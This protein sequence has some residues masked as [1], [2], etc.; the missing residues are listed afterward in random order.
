[1]QEFRIG[2]VGAGTI[3]TNH[4]NALNEIEG[5]RLVAVAEPREEAGRKLAGGNNAQWYSSLE[6]LL[7]QSDVDVVVLGTPS[8]LHADQ[9]VQAA[10][11]GKHVIT[12]KPMSI[13]LE[14]ADR[15]IEAARASGVT[16]SCIFQNRFNRD[17]L[18]LK[19]G[20]EAGLFGQPLIGN[21]FV[22][23][24]R[25]Q[26]YYDAAGG[27]RG[28]Y[29]MDGGGALMNQSIHTVDL[30][31]WVMGPV[32]SLCGYAETLA[33]NIEGEDTAS[34]TL[35]FQSGALGSIQG[36]TSAHKGRPVRV[37]IIGTEGAATL[38]GSKIT[39]WQ[40]SRE[41][42]V[43]TEEDIR[44]TREPTDGESFARSHITQMRLIF[45]ALREGRTPPIP[46]EEARK[47]LELVLG[48]YQS[49]R[50]GERVTFPLSASPVTA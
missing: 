32:E 29:Q 5:A 18:R 6:D 19:R 33:R 44:T 45:D 7:A 41:E 37:E 11:A 10:Q 3:S 16:L 21:A 48:V 38:E 25:K 40:P 8:G 42:E 30:L 2:L 43:L 35:R 34:A 28:T 27:W 31:Q 24:H 20:V 4:V 23:W 46:G 49:A 1:M 50:T 17:A 14:G 36:M 15:M 12:E 47:A 22:Y 26:E 9:A 13:T 39:V